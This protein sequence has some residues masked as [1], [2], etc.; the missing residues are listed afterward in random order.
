MANIRLQATARK[1]SRSM[2]DVS[3]ASCLTH[4]FGAIYA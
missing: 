1:R 3:G 2:P 4:S